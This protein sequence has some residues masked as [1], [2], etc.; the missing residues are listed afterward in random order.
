M[1]KLLAATVALFL[2]GISNAQPKP[3]DPV[4]QWNRLLATYYNPGKGFDYKALKARDAA[5]LQGVRQQLGRVNVAALNPKQQL[6]H[7]I[8][9]YNVNTVAT[10]V[11][12]YPTD[13]IR[14]LST[15]PIIRLNVFKKER[16]PVGDAKLSLNDVENEKIRDGFKDARIHFAINCAAK[17]CPPIRQTAFTGDTLDAQLDQQA[18]AFLNGPHGAR[19]KKDGDTLVITTTR[20]MDWFGDDFDKWAG[21]KA[22]F[23]RKYVSADKQRMIDQAKDIDFEYDDYDW[24]L[25]DWK[26]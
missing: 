4:A 16:V 26:R 1:R 13:S 2:V 21:G 17:S 23:I 9:V 24:S 10:I 7:W 3:A 12:G 5:A 15:D 20:I 6:A 14:D 25:N 11:E 19:F 22:A 18:H 8:N